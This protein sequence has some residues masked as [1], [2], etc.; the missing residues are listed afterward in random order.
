[1]LRDNL[2]LKNSK[3]IKLNC[4]SCGRKTHQIKTC[5]LIHYVPD[6]EKII[7]QYEYCYNQERKKILRKKKKIRFSFSKLQ[8]L[9][10]KFEKKINQ[11]KRDALTR[12]LEEKYT[13]SFQN[14]DSMEIENL[15]EQINSSKNDKAPKEYKEVKGTFSNL[16]IIEEKKDNFKNED[17]ENEEEKKIKEDDTECFDDPR[18]ININSLNAHS[19]ELVFEQEIKTNEEKMNQI[20]IN[21]P[22]QST[23]EN[24]PSFIEKQNNEGL[25]M[26][27]SENFSNIRKDSNSIGYYFDKNEFEKISHFTHYFPEM[28]FNKAIKIYEI[29]RMRMNL[30]KN[31][32]SKSKPSF[33]YENFEKIIES[34]LKKFNNYSFK[35]P[36]YKE[37]IL[38]SCER[39]SK[40]HERQKKKQLPEVS[41]PSKSLFDKNENFKE[42]NVDFSKMISVVLK[43]KIKNGKTEKKKKKNW[44]F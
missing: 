37:L 2:L 32:R 12:I 29:Q 25:N 35:L 21:I 3:V 10:K 22:K 28:N 18:P 26:K 19:N 1:M 11:E 33:S 38:R 41:S 9:A 17:E 36:R 6:K 15:I 4:F 31:I 20:K 44:F 24:I 42:K 40:K 5:P 16:E 43:K 34:K 27:S 23:Y 13:D 8:I 30:I 14:L 39:R 7:K